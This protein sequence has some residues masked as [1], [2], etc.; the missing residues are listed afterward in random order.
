MSDFLSSKDL[1]IHAASNWVIEYEF[2][3]K[4]LIGRLLSSSFYCLFRT[5]RSIMQ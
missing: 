3:L 2:H 4:R 1:R 5:K